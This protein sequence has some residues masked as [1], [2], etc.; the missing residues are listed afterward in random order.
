MS[1]VILTFAIN[2]IRCITVSLLTALSFAGCTNL[3]EEQEGMLEK[4]RLVQN[5]PVKRSSLVSILEI[6]DISS[7]QLGGGVRGGRMSFIETWQHP[8]GLTIT[9]YDSEYVG[10]M[11]IIRES[12]DAILNNPNRKATDFVRTLGAPPPRPTFEGFVVT[13]GDTKIYTSTE[14]ESE[15]DASGNRR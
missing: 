10:D 14:T 15:Q 5:F 7:E 12:I 9:A 2:M 8:S 6:G 13:K 4:A 11:A 3:T 1:Y